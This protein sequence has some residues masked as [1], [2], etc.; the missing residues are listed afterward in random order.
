MDELIALTLADSEGRHG[1]LEDFTPVPVFAE[2]LAYKLPV[3]RAY[4]FEDPSE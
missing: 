2:E 1:H 4:Y 3:Q